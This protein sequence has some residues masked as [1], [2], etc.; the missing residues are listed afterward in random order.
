MLSLERVMIEP[1]NLIGPLVMAVAFVLSAPLLAQEHS[2]RGSHPA[3]GEPDP[4]FVARSVGGGNCCHGTDCTPWHGGP[5]VPAVRD[6]IKGVTL[7]RWF[8]REDQRIDPM[9]L[10]PDVRGEPSI[11]IGTS[12][13][14]IGSTEL[15]R[16]YY[17]PS[18]T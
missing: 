6:G 4:Y 9:T 1:R 13:N 16:C 14:A 12:A 3:P 10:A 8:F 11:C 5:P 18:G 17:Y 7:G 15:P 2:P